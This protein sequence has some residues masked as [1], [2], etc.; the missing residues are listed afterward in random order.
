MSLD[1]IDGLKRPGAQV[2]FLLCEFKIGPLPALDLQGIDRHL[3]VLN[4][5]M[6]VSAPVHFPYFSCNS[7]FFS[8]EVMALGSRPRIAAI[9]L[10]GVPSRY[11][12]SN[13]SSC[14]GVQR[15]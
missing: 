13:S 14:S 2:K 11:R 4:S 12:R 15:A 9:F 5:P 1:R 8:R 3:W 7:S 10:R 6:M